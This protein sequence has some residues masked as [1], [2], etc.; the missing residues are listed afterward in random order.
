MENSVSGM[1]HY[2]CM[3]MRR[4]GGWKAWKKLTD[5]KSNCPKTKI[6]VVGTCSCPKQGTDFGWGRV[7]IGHFLPDEGEPLGPQ[8]NMLDAP[9]RIRRLWVDTPLLKHC[10]ASLGQGVYSKTH[11]SF[12]SFVYFKH[13]VQ[14][15][16]TVC[17]SEQF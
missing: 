3:G 7:G 12:N 11:N 10:V 5:D 15:D 16:E 1:I 9:F 13:A 14:E 8:Q 17:T 4:V 6:S 2:P